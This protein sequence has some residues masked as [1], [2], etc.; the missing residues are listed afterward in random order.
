MVSYIKELNNLLN[1]IQLELFDI[2]ITY[3]YWDPTFLWRFS[4]I[5][6]FVFFFFFCNFILPIHLIIP[7]SSK[8]TN[9]EISEKQHWRQKQRFNAG[10]NAKKLL[11]QKHDLL[12][13]SNISEKNWVDLI[14]T[15]QLKIIPTLNTCILRK[16]AQKR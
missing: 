3:H 9:P 5:F 1:I 13:T 7:I 15:W 12:K 4:F 6:S 10:T 8:E 14:S 2:N 11:Q 16:K